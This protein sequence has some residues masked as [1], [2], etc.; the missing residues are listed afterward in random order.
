MG[1]R[2]AD[3]APAPVRRLTDFDRLVSG[4]PSAHGAVPGTGNT[5]SAT[6]PVLLDFSDRPS[7]ATK[8]RGTV[9]DW[10][11]LVLAVAV[12]PVGLL[13]SAVSRIISYRRHGWTTAVA[14]IATALSIVLTLVLG[15]GAV[16]YSIVVEREAAAAA[17]LAQAR[18]LCDALAATPGVLETPGYGW[19][20]AVAEIP[21]TLE[22]M[23]E[24]QLHWQQLADLAPESAEGNLRAIANQAETLVVSVETSQAIDRNGNL[25]AMAAVTGNS[26]LPGWVD[27]NCV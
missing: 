6:A 20:T 25:V 19:P 21:V 15:A 17:V 10:I 7:R 2:V 1:R 12:P 8:P 26:G 27:R 4:R 3:S 14:T 24:Y 16:A 13:I 22:A 18:P 5:G 11:S 9:L 23:R